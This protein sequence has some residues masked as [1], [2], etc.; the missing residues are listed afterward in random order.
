MEKTRTV[1]KVKYPKEKQKLDTKTEA[2]L[3]QRARKG[4]SPEERDTLRAIARIYDLPIMGI[5]LLGGNPYV[6]VTGLDHKV[7]KNWLDKGWVKEEIPRCIQQPSKDN[8]WLAGFE[9]TI[10]MFN[11][12]AFDNAVKSISSADGKVTPSLINSLRKAYTV[13]FKAEGWASPATCEGI[14]YKYEGERG[15]KEKTELLRENVTMMAERKSSNRAKRAAVGCGLTSVEEVMGVDSGAVDTQFKLL[16]E[17][18]EEKK[19]PKAQPETATGEQLLQIR[20][21]LESLGEKYEER[22]FKNLSPEGADKV[23]QGLE[24]KLRGKEKEQ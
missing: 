2:A 22:R 13:E 12:V 9:T 5:I 18:K 24:D 19:G 20:Q 16:E 4:L 23:I 1:P 7:Q 14:A 3:M 15:H 21:L 8:D 6:N 10:R 17:E 11:Q